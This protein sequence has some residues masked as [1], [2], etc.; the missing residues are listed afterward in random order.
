MAKRCE[1]SC[2]PA[3]VFRATFFSTF[4]RL[5]AQLAKRPL[6]W[7]GGKVNWVDV[8]PKRVVRDSGQQSCASTWV[9]GSFLQRV[10][11]KNAVLTHDPHQQVDFALFDDITY[12]QLIPFPFAA[13]LFPTRDNKG[14]GEVADIQ[15][16]TSSYLL[17]RKLFL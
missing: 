15:D 6:H 12:K 17:A 9:E 1:F 10:V 4:A 8:H 14:G 3:R 13:L 7:A 16:V 2:H 5:N 11:M